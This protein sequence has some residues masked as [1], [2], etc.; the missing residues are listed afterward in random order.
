MEN[1]ILP[2]M[3][4]EM[5]KNVGEDK[6]NKLDVDQLSEVSGGAN[7][8]ENFRTYVRLVKKVQG[9][10]M[11][12]GYRTACCPECGWELEVVTLYAKSNDYENRDANNDMLWCHSCNAHN[13]AEKWVINSFNSK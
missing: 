3:E 12:N 1:K 8:Y 6:I 11:Q 13:K 10:A 9:A 7:G 4:T 2:E 5:E